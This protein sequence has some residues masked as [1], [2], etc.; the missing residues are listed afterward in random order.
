MPCDE[1]QVES[2]RE[3]YSSVEG[4][5]SLQFWRLVSP[6]LK[7]ILAAVTCH[8]NLK[9]S[10]CVV[11]GRRSF[12]VTMGDI[13]SFNMGVGERKRKEGRKKERKKEKKK[14]RKEGKK[15]ERKKMKKKERKQAFTITA[16]T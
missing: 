6:V 4:T 3:L 15:K 14:G 1:R 12:H 13:A 9:V 8:P 10:K 5:N 11:N 16:S 7:L 2:R